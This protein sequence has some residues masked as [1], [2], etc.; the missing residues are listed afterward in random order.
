M[1][2]LFLLCPTIAL[3]LPEEILSELP[4]EA[5]SLMEELEEEES[6]LNEGMKKLLKR[7]VSF[8]GVE[9]RSALSSAGMLLSAVMLC[10]LIEAGHDGDGTSIPLYVSLVGTL[11][12]TAIAAGNMQTMIGLG[13]VTIEQLNLLSDTIL[14]A[15]AAVVAGCGGIVSATVRQGATILF[16]E[17]LLTVIH[18]LL[19][20]LINFYMIAAAADAMLPGQRLKTIA[21]AIRKGVTWLLCGLLTL[22]TAY[23]RISGAA[24][25]A[26]D[27]M[28]VQLARSAISTAVPVVGGIIS[29]AADTVLAGALL[30]KSS[31]GIAGMLGVMAICIVPFLKLAVQYLLYK[32]TAFL[33]GMLGNSLSDYL[34]GLGN[35]FG[36]VLGMTGCCGV[37]LLIS[38][39]S[40][41]SVVIV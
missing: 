29:E 33:A 20:P 15:L 23:L 40:F 19:L 25:S 9:F 37:L 17:I 1:L 2:L 38:I 4:D 8:F 27:T 41:I 10:G 14:P 21:E 28:T 34:A 18:H 26:S 22:F 12:I 13:E 35:A 31:L 6:S 39:S 5:R 30:L 3:A 36:M 7:C 16:S 24:A 11:S 32:G